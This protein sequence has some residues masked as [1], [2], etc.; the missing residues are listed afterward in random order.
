MY[1]AWESVECLQTSRPN[2]SR[3][4]LLVPLATLSDTS[5]TDN[6]SFVLRGVED[7]TYEHRPIPEGELRSKDRE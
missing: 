3:Q 7:L 5:M 6:I 2:N 1:E 4:R